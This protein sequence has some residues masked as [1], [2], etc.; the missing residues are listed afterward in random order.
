MIEHVNVPLLQ[1]EPGL[2]CAVR[3][4]PLP[5]FL[6][7]SDLVHWPPRVDSVQV[8]YLCAVESHS[9]KHSLG[10]AGS[11]QLISDLLVD[12]RGDLSSWGIAAGVLADFGRAPGDGGVVEE[13]LVEG[14]GVRMG[15]Q[16]TDGEL[17][18]DEVG[19]GELLTHQLR[20]ELG[21]E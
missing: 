9:G 6:W 12:F 7:S 18:V 16:A 11:L 21:G 3:S 15:Q 5:A 17:L 8:S 19:H 13:L 14:L 2:V 10:D 1:L 20:W 4:I